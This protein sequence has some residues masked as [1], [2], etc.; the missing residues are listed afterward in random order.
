PSSIENTTAWLPSLSLSLHLSP[1]LSISLH[2]S[3]SLSLPLSVIST[4]PNPPLSLSLSFVLSF[5]ISLSLSA[6]LVNLMKGCPIAFSINI[7][8]QSGV[9]NE[10]LSPSSPSL[11]LSL[12]LFLSPSLSLS[13]SA[14]NPFRSSHCFFHFSTPF[15]TPFHHNC[16][17]LQH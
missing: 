3:L 8:I 14:F 9:N 5:F 10:C 1:S 13:Y 16:G 6:S 17:A 12:P 2:P 4:L 11:F 7:P 15:S